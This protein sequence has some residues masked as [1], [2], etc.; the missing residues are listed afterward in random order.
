MEEEEQKNL[1]TLFNCVKNIAKEEL[2]FKLKK[3]LDKKPNLNQK[4]NGV[5]AAAM[6][7]KTV[8]Q[9]L[10][11]KANKKEIGMLARECLN[12]LE[13]VNGS[14]NPL[15]ETLQSLACQY[16]H[17]DRKIIKRALLSEIVK[18]LKLKDVRKFV[19]GTVTQYE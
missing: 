4:K 9:T 5:K 14:D 6:I 12:E 13:A 8:C 3:P 11:P 2:V 16:Q 15:G 7:F 1:D 18:Q 19:D 10:H 17:C